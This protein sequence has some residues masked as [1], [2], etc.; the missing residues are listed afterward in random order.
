MRYT[1]NQSRSGDSRPTH[2]LQTTVVGT[3]AAALLIPMLVLAMLYPI[4]AAA[5]VGAA[6]ATWPLVRGFRQLYRARQREGRTRRVC[7]PATNTC[8][9]L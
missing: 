8:T 4:T 7:V 3:V 9:E 5:V 1:T 6:L 2:S